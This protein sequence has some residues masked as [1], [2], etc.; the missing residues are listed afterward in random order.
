MLVLSRKTDETII[1]GDVIKIVVLGI[2][3]DKVKLGVEAPIS[4]RILREELIEQTG[5]ENLNALKSPLLTFD[6][7]SIET[8]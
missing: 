3:G 8:A 6:L 1:V 2:E 7:E 5:E 4:M